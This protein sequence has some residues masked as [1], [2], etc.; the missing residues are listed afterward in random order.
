VDGRFTMHL[1]YLAP[2]AFYCALSLTCL[3]GCCRDLQKNERKNKRDFRQVACITELV[4]FEEQ[5]L[6]M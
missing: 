1:S 5:Q 6:V 4:G 2:W 3:A